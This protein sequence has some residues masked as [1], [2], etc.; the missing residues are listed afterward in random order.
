M[1]SSLGIQVNLY[2]MVISPSK[3]GPFLVSTVFSLTT[4]LSLL[5]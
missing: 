3:S 1:R 4:D 2:M 5:E